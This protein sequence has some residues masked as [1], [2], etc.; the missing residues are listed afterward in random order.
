MLNLVLVRVSGHLSMFQS[1]T[2]KRF[3]M[4]PELRLLVTC[5]QET[6]S[7]GSVSLLI[8]SPYSSHSP[9]L[10]SDPRDPGGR[11]GPQLSPGEPDLR[12][13]TLG[14]ALLDEGDF[15]LLCTDG[16][17]DNLDPELLGLQPS[18]VGVKAKAWDELT[19]EVGTDAKT[20]RWSCTVLC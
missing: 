7:T 20:V 5:F 13:L 4:T 9:S 16:V 8:S 19:P 12:N 1:E 2:Q 14:Q 11:L 3:A 10:S 17:H 6:G 15:L 18:D